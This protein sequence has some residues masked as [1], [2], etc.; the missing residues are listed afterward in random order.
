MSDFLKLNSDKRRELVNTRQRHQAWREASVRGRE[1][2]GSM[3]WSTTKGHTYLTRVSYDWQG[4]RR[5]SLLGPK[6]A[7]TERLKVEWETNRADVTK[8]LDVLTETLTCQPAVNRVLELGRVP[9]L[10]AR[11]I[12]ALDQHAL[13][14]NG[15][16][17]LGTS[18][19]Y[20]YEAVAGVRIDPGVTTTEDIDL[21]LDSRRR[22]S[23]VVTTDLDQTS[24]HAILRRIDK[25]FG[26]SAQE[27]RATNDEG[28][29]VDLIRPMCDSPWIDDHARIGAE[30]DD[31]SAIGIHGLAWHES[32]PPFE[33]TAIDEKGAPLRIVKS[34]PRV[35]IATSSG[36]RPVKSVI[37]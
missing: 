36:C 27:F 6:S 20:G 11:I 29:L 28:Y 5:Q 12:R 37:L 10:A 4:C 19:I 25:S 7:E 30:S 14:G 13:L 35:F 34:D 8:R 22:L 15:V 18:A 24:L 17:M 21:L 23:F 26:R 9:L 1:M 31:L 33:A 3:V 2:R 32:A 16:R